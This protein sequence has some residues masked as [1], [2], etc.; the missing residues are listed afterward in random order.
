MPANKILMVL[1]GEPP[2]EEILKWRMEETDLSIAVDA[3]WLAFRHSDLLPNV[4]IGD[5]DSTGEV[6]TSNEIF[7][8]VEVIVDKEQNNTDFQKAL[9]YI[10]TKYTPQEII[11]LGALGNR[12]DHLISNLFIVSNIDPKIVVIIDSRKEWLRRVTSLTPLNI[13]GQEGATL[14]LLPLSSCSGVS[15]S[16]LKWKL[17]NENLSLDSIFSQSN[18]CSSNSVNISLQSGNLIVF[19]QK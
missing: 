12:T 7:S 5:M 11:I 1:G 18:F 14:S 3:G 16:G 6:D 10:S 9:L 13:V 2:D 4:F 17:E 15:A 19:L 8:S